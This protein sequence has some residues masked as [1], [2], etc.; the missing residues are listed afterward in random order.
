MKIG[1]KSLIVV[2]PTT[3]TY[4][5][6]RIHNKVSPINLHCAH[7]LRITPVLAVHTPLQ[8]NR[9]TQALII[10][11][12]PDR[13]PKLPR[14][15]VGRVGVSRSTRGPLPPWLNRISGGAR[16]RVTCHL[17]QLGR[18]YIYISIWLAVPIFSRLYINRFFI[19]IYIY[20]YI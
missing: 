20:I 12:L 6:I 2:E 4:S 8:A 16:A 5:Y 14:C 18:L 7:H 1:T 13:G 3:S 11:A 15:T 19:Y 17:S 10:I 9:P